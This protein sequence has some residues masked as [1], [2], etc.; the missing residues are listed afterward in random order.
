MS[1]CRWLKQAERLFDQ[2][3]PHRPEVE[4][5]VA[6]CSQCRARLRALETLRRGVRQANASPHISDEQLPAFLAGV[7][8]GL[9]KNEKRPGGIWALASLATAALIAAVSGWVIFAQHG[10][11]QAGTEVESVSTDIENA[12]IDSYSN[13]DGTATVWVHVA[14]EDLW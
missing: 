12:T 4:Q 6:G 1:N 8:H 14:E 7:R 10:E 3:G 11:V 2:E 5:H 13:E 9:N